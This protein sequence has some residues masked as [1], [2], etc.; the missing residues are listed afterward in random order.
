MAKKFVEQPLD[1]PGSA[2]YYIYVN[3]ILYIYLVQYKGET[4]LQKFSCFTSL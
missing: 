3:F 4:I 1:S 2:K